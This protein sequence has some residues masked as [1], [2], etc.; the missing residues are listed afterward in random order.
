MLYC[1]RYDRRCQQRSQEFFSFFRRYF[2]IVTA[3][4]ITWRRLFDHA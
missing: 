2:D 3:V 1:Y 4:E